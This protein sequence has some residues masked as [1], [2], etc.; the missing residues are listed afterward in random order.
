MNFSDYIFQKILMF[1][2]VNLLDCNVLVKKKKKK[3][4]RKWNKSKGK[5][6]SAFENTGEILCYKQK[7]KTKG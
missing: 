2:P 5:V 3:K 6:L 1:S 7:M 4:K